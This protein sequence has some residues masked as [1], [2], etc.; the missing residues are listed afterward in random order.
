MIAFGCPIIDRAKYSR[1]AEPGIRRAA[2]PDSTLLLRHDAPSIQAAYN[3]MLEEA[4]AR[5]DLEA[6]VLLHEDVELRD[7]D[8]ADK[9]RAC[10][11]D[12]LVA[13]V[14]AVG[15]QDV[16]SLDW[17]RGGMVGGVM[18]PALVGPDVVLGGA[19]PRGPVESVDGLLLALSPWAVRTLRFDERFA[20]YFHGYD[21]DL[22]F[23]ARERGRHVVVADIDVV[24]HAGLDFFDRRTW[25]PAYRLLHRKWGR[26]RAVAAGST[27]AQRHRRT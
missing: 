3:S 17:W 18:A 16:R 23:Q 21:V 10:M 26:R 25:V 12:P 13:V 7:R 1:F 27:S 15:S 20:P 19:S 8:L 6:L 11:G 9:L 14:G 24:H 22:C 2:E 5:S 4:G